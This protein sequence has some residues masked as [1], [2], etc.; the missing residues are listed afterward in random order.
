MIGSC[1]GLTA[2]NCILLNIMDIRYVYDIMSSASNKTRLDDFGADAYFLNRSLESSISQGFID[3][4]IA[5][6]YKAQEM[7]VRSGQSREK[8]ENAK[9]IM[10]E[11][12]ETEEKGYIFNVTFN[13]KESYVLLWLIYTLNF[14]LWPKNIL[15]QEKVDLTHSDLSMLVNLLSAIPSYSVAEQKLFGMEIYRLTRKNNEEFRRLLK[16]KLTFSDGRRSSSNKIVYSALCLRMNSMKA[17]ISKWEAMVRTDGD[18]DVRDIDE[19]LE[20]LRAQ[21]KEFDTGSVVINQL[22]NA[23]LLKSYCKVFDEDLDEI[24][25]LI[26]AIDFN[27]LVEI[28]DDIKHVVWGLNECNVDFF[29]DCRKSIL[30][31]HGRKVAVDELRDYKDVIAEAQ[32]AI[33]SASALFEPIVRG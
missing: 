4:R 13:Y 28:Y 11:I 12:E 15:S 17:E 21:L 5:R 19:K 20:D 29:D 23:N 22:N 31:T 8:V 32:Q 30:I 2:A 6:K 24:K 9:R 10:R 18:S 26:S 33:D 14:N 27:K 25:S 7:I 1:L 16:A 3:A